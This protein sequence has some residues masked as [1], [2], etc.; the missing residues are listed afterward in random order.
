M[1]LSFSII[2]TLCTFLV[3]G[4]SRFQEHDIFPANSPNYK[5]A[6]QED[7]PAW[8]KMMYEENPNY[9]EIVDDYS[10]WKKL[11]SKE[12]RAVERYFKI[13]SRNVQAYVG[14]DGS[15][16]LSNAE[17][18]FTQLFKNQT[19]I[20]LNNDLKTPSVEDW[21]FWGPKETF[22][23]NE[24]GSLDV[25]KSNPW[26]VNVYSFDVS[27]I[28]LSTIYCGTETGFVNKSID[29]GLT[30]TLLAQEY[31]FGGGVTSVAIN[32]TND[33][34]V[35][36]AAGGQIHKTTD[37]GL[38]WA[39]KLSG[40]NSFN[41]DKITIDPSNPLK[42][43]TAGSSGIHVST[44][45]GENWT[46]V[47]TY[48]SYDIHTKVGNSNILYCISEIN[49]NFAIGISTD[50]G[51]SFTADTAF[52][53]QI[54]DVSGGLIAVTE[55]APEQLTAILLSENNSPLLYQG[56]MQLQSWELL[57]TGQT[58]AFPLNN[59]QGFF[60]LVLEVSPLDASLV[61]AGTSTLYKSTNGGSNFSIVGGYGGQFPIHPDIQ[62]M[63]ILT[64]GSTWVATDGGFTHSTDHFT[65]VQNAFSRNNL[66]VGSDM[67]GFDQGWNEDLIVGGRYHNG[68]TAIAD[69]YQPKA[70]R[71]G[72]A[73]SPTGWI[74][75]GKSKHVAFND[76]GAGW[77]LPNTAESQP[78][79][80]FTF[81]KYPN[82]DEYG[83][84]RGNMLFHPN[85][86]EILY[87]GEGNG[88]WKSSDMGESFELL[89]DFGSRIRFCQIA[90]ND[91]NVIYA[92]IVDDGLFRS[93]DGGITWTEKPALTNGLN[94]T[95]FWK[96][97]LHFEISPTNADVIYACLQNGTWSAN[98]GKIFK[99][100]DGGDNWED[101]SG[102][103][104]AFT[105]VLVIQP[106]EQGEDLLYLF[107][108]NR[109]GEPGKCFI[110]KKD[111]LDWSIY[112]ESYPAGM[113][114][115]QALAFFRDSKIRI[116][117][118][119]GVWENQLSEPNFLPIVQPWV[120]NSFTNCMLDTLQFD[121]HSI[122]NHENCTWEWKISP[123]PLY[124]EDKNLRNP[125]VVLGA[126]GSYNVTLTLTKDGI[127]YTK[128]I[129]N[130]I[131]TIACPSLDNCENASF[132]PKDI[133]ELEFVDSEETGDPG[134]ATMAFDNDPSTIWHTKWSTGSDPY[135]HEIQIDMGDKYDVQEFIYYPRQI[136]QNGWIKDYELY[137]TD[138]L[139]D[140][141]DVASEGAFEVSPAPH[142]IVFD[143][144]VTGRYFRLVALSEAN[145]NAWASASEFE[146]KGCYHEV[147]NTTNLDFGTLKAF[148][149]PTTGLFEITL[150]ENSDYEY[151]IYSIS[152]QMIKKGMIENT[153]KSLQ[154]D[155]SECSNGMYLVQLTDNA[156]RTYK[157]KMIKSE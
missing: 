58:N 141:G 128:T 74:M 84:R 16:D 153:G 105:K 156:Q 46:K 146:I 28:N 26:Q 63:K 22:W 37:G 140:W 112:G 91:P 139:N 8:A 75:K 59:G 98:K 125:K 115:I 34:I 62:A 35:Y 149:V 14:V 147:S 95:P 4:Q 68:N 53:D 79:G 42:I 145:G 83:G 66:L 21:T 87:L 50:G 80:R 15:I 116:G 3:F 100:T 64:D 36:V 92:D 122:V 154:I 129:E 54:Q 33:D 2:L 71:M 11:D 124:L 132:L 76:L 151:K 101:W 60:D 82:M 65:S 45:A 109:N 120:N 18:Y 138:D 67:W 106:D 41:A 1:K 29:N 40:A 89:H 136:G 12:F 137:F 10:Q 123:T 9:L 127:P 48:P 17:Q 19:N 119:A 143:V 94:G 78:L 85:Y 117:G 130:M 107:T 31:P 103:L 96:G 5:P 113:S 7:F 32:P 133:W 6:Y 13:W 90:F 27:E 86:Y 148:P 52:P 99:S 111:D 142:K 25:P 152:G 77:I 73:E 110:R 144:P 131:E 134:L 49:G 157:V 93:D 126:A 56:N 81:S 121:D 155:L 39:P 118:N 44:D 30:W 43:F 135:P 20:P 102:T 69:F 23:L 51:V 38:N 55:A 57:A 88:F 108:S 61:F 114:P 104:D 150:P 47:W 97:K 70:L 72:G 24:S